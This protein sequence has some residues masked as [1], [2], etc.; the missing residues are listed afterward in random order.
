[1]ENVKEVGSTNFT[2]GRYRDN[3]I[4]R[5]RRYLCSE[6]ATVPLWIEEKK[7]LKDSGLKTVN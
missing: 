1:M 7:R 3:R 5:R 2:S 6:K 4:S